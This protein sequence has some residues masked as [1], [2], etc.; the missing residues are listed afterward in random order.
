MIIIGIGGSDHD[1]SCCLL[2]DGELKVYIEEERLTKEKH[3]NGV[4]SSMLKSVDYCL[5]YMGMKYDDVDYFISN[6]IY[7]P[8]LN[9]KKMYMN[10]LIRINHHLAHMASAF[11]LSEF[12]EAAMLISDGSGSI[13]SH[14]HMETITLGF[15]KNNKFEVLDKVYGNNS[16][17][18][19]SID[20]VK[21]NSFGRFYSK[22]SNLCGFE[23]HNDGK[24]MGLASYGKPRFID[25]FRT[26]FQLTFTPNGLDVI[27]DFNSQFK[28]LYKK[29]FEETNEEKK[30]QLKAD[31]AYAAQAV[32]E[33]K[34][35]EIINYLYKKTKCPNLCYAGGVALNSVL[36]GKIKR[37]TPFDNVY[38]PPVPNDSGT[39]IGAALYGYYNLFTDK[40]PCHKQLNTAFW[41]KEYDKEHYQKAILKYSDQIVIE[42]TYTVLSVV[43]D[44]INKKVIGWYQGRSEI[45]PRALGNRS[46]LADPRHAEMKDIINNKVKFR[47]SFRPFAPIVLEEYTSDIFDTDFIPNPFMLYVGQVK[48][49]KQKM[50]P[51]VT[52]VDGSARLQTLSY[53]NN[54]KLYDVLRGFYQKT[55]VPVLMNTSFNTKS[56]P[57]VE[58][59]EDAINCMLSCEMDVLYLGDYRIIKKEEKT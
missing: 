49:E 58:T 41:G 28:N 27:I 3:G 44:L 18:P 26:F 43:D 15:A 4:K 11:Y 32:L 13:M 7:S 56:K 6:D 37:M 29:L 16:L 12:D 9:N 24:L 1:A 23:L 57:I 40:K 10:N 2:E 34:T 46:I 51:A 25:M 8:R 39:A 52:H 53:Q 48:E 5:E 42:E 33:E 31:Y 55:G 47:E 35:F 38:I 19:E 54:P 14:F 36:N 59:P 50:I 45:G 30:F 17:N 21:G 22:V 20:I